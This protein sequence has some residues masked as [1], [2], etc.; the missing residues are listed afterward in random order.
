[1]LYITF[2]D[3]DEAKKHRS[4]NG[5]WIFLPEDGFPI[6]FALGFT[7]SGIFT[8]RATRGLNGTLI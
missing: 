8:H 2:L 4:S 6:W 1:M 7:A 3:L 5:G